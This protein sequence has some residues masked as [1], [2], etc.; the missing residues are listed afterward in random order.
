[1]NRSTVLE[2]R[3]FQTNTWICTF[4]QI[5]KLEVGQS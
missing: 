1:M 3:T 4:R 2:L 5:I